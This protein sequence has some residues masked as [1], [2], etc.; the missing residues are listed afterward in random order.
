MLHLTV[1]RTLHSTLYTLNFTLHT[2]DSKLTLHTLHFALRSPHFTPTLYTWHS[3]LYVYTLHSHFNLYAFALYTLHF[4][5][6]PHN[7]AL[8]TLDTVWNLGL[9]PLSS[10]VRTSTCRPEVSPLAALLLPTLPKFHSG[11]DS[12]PLNFPLHCALCTPHFTL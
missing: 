1:K 5:L 12:G 4:T 8:F 10:C 11:A 6:D 2:L 7:F 3:T 9:A